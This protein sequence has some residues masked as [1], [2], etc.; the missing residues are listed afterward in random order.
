M[1]YEE[2]MCQVSSNLGYY[3]SFG[4][5]NDVLAMLNTSFTNEFEVFISRFRDMRV[6]K[7]ANIN[8]IS[9]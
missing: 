8:D 5:K 4:R 6:V 3:I 1:R 9:M 2:G 7:R